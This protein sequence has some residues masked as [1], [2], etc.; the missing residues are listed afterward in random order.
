MLDD[1]KRSLGTVGD[2]FTW[3]TADVE[4]L[5][6]DEGAFDVV[7]AHFML[8]HAEDVSAAVHEISRVLVPNGLLMAATNG[9]GHMGELRELA[10]PVIP[11][12]AG[13]PLYE[14]FGLENGESVLGTAFDDVQ[15][16]R[17]P[18]S[19]V[20]TER[21]PLIDYLL[22]I[23]GDKTHEPKIRALVDEHWEPE[24]GFHITKN[25]GVFVARM[26]R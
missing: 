8:Y 18:D 9:V 17:R 15:L 20:V 12:F 14:S 1:A 25:S 24:G 6:F 23:D 11:E 26:A 2:S 4:S 22:S 3:R 21:Q 16:I 13:R 7:F 5:P 10:R 19:L